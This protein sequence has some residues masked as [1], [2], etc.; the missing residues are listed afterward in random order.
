MVGFILSG[1]FQLMIYEEIAKRF[2]IQTEAFRL[3]Y[4]DDDEE[5]WVLLVWESD[6]N[7][8]LEIQVGYCLDNLDVCQV[9]EFMRSEA[10]C[11]PDHS[12]YGNL[13]LMFGKKKLID[14]VEQLFSALMKEGL[15]PDTR[16]YTELIRAY[17]K[18]DMIEK[19]METYELM[20]ASGCIPDELTLTIMKRN[21]KN[22]GRG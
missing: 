12:L 2:K 15:K 22:A 9:F 10:W 13:M 5:K 11:E 19:A 4:K 18:V 6:K 8:C 7:K 14:K 1:W 21:L 3:K 16:A 20:K 17:L